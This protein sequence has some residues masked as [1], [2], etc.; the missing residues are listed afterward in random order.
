[1]ALPSHLRREILFGRAASAQ[2]L[3]SMLVLDAAGNIVIDAG[4]D[5]PREGNFA[6]RPH[7][8]VQRDHRA[9]DLYQ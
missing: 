1:M 7:F 4:S 2:Y 3:G 6:D 9:A 5:T 8:T